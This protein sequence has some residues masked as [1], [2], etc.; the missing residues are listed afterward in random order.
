MAPHSR[1]STSRGPLQSKKKARWASPGQESPCSDMRPLRNLFCHSCTLVKDIQQTC[2]DQFSVFQHPQPTRNESHL[3]ALLCSP[4]FPM[5]DEHTLHYAHL[6]SNKET[7]VWT[8]AFS[9]SYRWQY[10]YV[11][12][13]VASFW[14]NLLYGGC[15]VF[16]WL[17]LIG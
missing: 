4:R 8:C 16:I 11:K 6:Q 15:S 9:L 17:P 13:S 10:R 5:L 2:D 7:T 3:S 1:K 12:N 14:R